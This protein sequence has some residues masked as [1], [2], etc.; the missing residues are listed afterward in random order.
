M[1]GVARGSTSFQTE[2]VSSPYSMPVSRVSSFAVV[3]NTPWVKLV[4]CTNLA[5]PWQEDFPSGWLSPGIEEQS[6]SLWA[7][8]NSGCYQATRSSLRRPLTCQQ[9]L[10]YFLALRHREPQTSLSGPGKRK[11]LILEETNYLHGVLSSSHLRLCRQILESTKRRSDF[12]AELWLSTPQLHQYGV[13]WD[14]VSP[15]LGE[16]I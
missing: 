3:A 13:I 2:Q 12:L 14:R 9:L 10:V 7:P 8:R 15:V 11:L 6:L 5:F 16:M 1:A 4:G